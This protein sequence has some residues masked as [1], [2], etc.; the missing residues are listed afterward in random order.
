MVLL[1]Y[2]LL[3]NSPTKSRRLAGYQWFADWPRRHGGLAGEPRW[4]GNNHNDDRRNRP[5]HQFE[6]VLLD[7]VR[8]G[9]Q[10]TQKPPA[11]L[12]RSMEQHRKQDAAL[13]MLDEP[14]HEHGPDDRSQDARDIHLANQE[15]GQMPCGM[16]HAEDQA[17]DERSVW[18]GCEPL[19]QAW[20]REA[21]PAQLLAQRAAEH[22]IANPQW[23]SKAAKKCIF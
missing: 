15:H 2:A 4:P 19:E 11:V 12:V 9:K 22:H 20:Q 7:Y 18:V 6:P 21:T 14:G 13:S 16:D 10:W 5:H 3:V 17:G 23:L 1:P 8:A